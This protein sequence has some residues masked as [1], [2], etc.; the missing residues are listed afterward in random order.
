MI[1]FCKNLFTRG[2]SS[3]FLTLVAGTGFAQATPIVFAPILTRLYTPQDFGVTALYLSL[4]SILG[5]LAS[6]RYEAAI[7][8]P[9]DDLIAYKLVKLC[10]LVAIIIALFL[11]LALLL[12]FDFISRLLGLNELGKI[13]YLLP[14]GMVLTAIFQSYNYWGIRNSNYAS[15]AIANTVRSTATPCIQLIASSLTKVLAFGLISGN[16]LGQAVASLF[17]YFK[18]RDLTANKVDKKFTLKSYSLLAKDYKQMPIFGLPG[19]LLDT[20][21]LQLPILFLTKFF[22]SSIVGHFSLVFRV[23]SIPTRLFSEILSKLLLKKVSNISNSIIDCGSTVSL[24]LKTTV[25]LIFFISPI[26]VVLQ[27]W[28]EEMFAFVFGSD[29]KVAGSYASILV[30]AVAIRFIVSPLSSVL[31]LK[32]HMFK[33]FCWQVLYF[34]TLTSTLLWASNKAF[35]EFLFFFVVHEI[36]LYLIYFIFILFASYKI[37]KKILKCVEFA[38]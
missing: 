35:E 5:V 7:L 10:I 9:K 20:T 33:G 30:Y 13:M 3:G 25:Y 12:W 1:S 4:A 18:N 8:Q 11:M 14:L 6:L 23:L 37:D 36:F 2:K 27:I 16:L 22:E 31:S 38:E 32:R 17:I 15:I 26:V 19:A 24:I 28:G 21:A 34:I 29:W